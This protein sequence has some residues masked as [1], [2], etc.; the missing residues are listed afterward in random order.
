MAGTHLSALPVALHQ[1]FGQVCQVAADIMGL[2]EAVLR[3]AGLRFSAE[4]Q[5]RRDTGIESGGH[6]GVKAGSPT[7]ASCSAAYAFLRKIMSMISRFGLPI[8]FGCTPVEALIN[9]SSH[10]NP[11]C[12]PT[13]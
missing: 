8:T 6:I 1:P 2:Q 5:N 10:R 4:N 3:S 7:I 13:R 9:A 12:I 11:G